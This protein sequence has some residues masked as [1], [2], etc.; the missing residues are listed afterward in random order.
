M[1]DDITEGVKH[2][3]D[4][5][6]VLTLLGT[7]ASMLPSIAAVLTIVWTTIRII[8]SATVKGIVKKHFGVD[9]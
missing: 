5:L 4:A 3:L 1:T 2:A 6:S 7:L 8:E 9:Y